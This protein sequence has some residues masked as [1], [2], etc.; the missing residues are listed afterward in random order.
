MSVTSARALLARMPRSSWLTLALLLSLASVVNLAFMPDHALELSATSY[1]RAD[2]GFGAAYDLL[3]EL[4]FEVARARVPYA[5]L[6]GDQPLWLIAPE[7][8]Q[9]SPAP[10]EQLQLLDELR[11]WIE[12]G[13]TAVL[14]GAD[15]E[16]LGAF[17][18]ALGA[19]STSEQVRVRGPL[20]PSGRV[21]RIDELARFA[22]CA[23]CEVLLEGGAPFALLERVGMGHVIALADARPFR[24][25]ELALADHSLLVADLARAF[26]APR[27]D[28]R[29]HGL[30]SEVGLARALGL[31]RLSLLLAGFVLLAGVWAWHARSV[32]G[33]AI[34]PDLAIDP[35]LARF[36]ESLTVLYGRKGRS[37]AAAVYRAYVHGF[38]HRLR[39]AVYGRGRGSDALLSDKLARELRDDVEL[40]AWLE[41]QSPPRTTAELERAV[42]RMERYMSEG[43]WQANR[44]L[45]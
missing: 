22:A 29:S 18:L 9:D 38:R 20:A 30:G 19:S 3:H 45:E 37:D 21:V 40:R 42:Q 25:Q 6:A 7:L 8:V 39:R 43:P 15:A 14:I 32:P 44:V 36:V 28:E 27:F 5:Q 12:S 31:G 24:N 33:P 17:G 34:E 2:A 11:P 13:G 10:A 35:N 41:G 26:G 16:T 1:G 4:G 23:D